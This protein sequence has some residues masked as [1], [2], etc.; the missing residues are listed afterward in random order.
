MY[1][2]IDSLQYPFQVSN[3]FQTIKLVKSYTYTDKYIHIQIRHPQGQASR[4][5]DGEVISLNVVMAKVAAEGSSLLKAA[6]NLW[7]TQKNNSSLR[8]MTSP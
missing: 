6:H 3:T 1:R 7:L 8:I 4:Q 2:N 5:D